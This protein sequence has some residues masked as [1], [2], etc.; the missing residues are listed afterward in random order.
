[1]SRIVETIRADRGGAYTNVVQLTDALVEAGHEAFVVGPFEQ[2]PEIRGTV[3]PLDVNR[4]VS[5]G[6]D[7]R[8]VTRFAGIVRELEPDLVHGHGSKGGLLARLGRLGS[9]RTPVVFTPHLYSFDNYFARPAQRHL[10]RGVERVL[11]PLASRVTA[12][13][14]AERLSAAK[15]G[16]ASR[17]RLVYNGVDPIRLDSVHP[18]I[19]ELRARGPVVCTVAELRDSKGVPRLVDA[20]AIVRERHPDAQLA[21]AGDGA[22]RSLVE[23]R[24]AAHGL[25][26]AAHL[27]GATPGADQVLAGAS[28]F[29]NA[30]YAEGFPYTVIEAMSAGLPVV[31]TDVGGTSEAI[32]TDGEAGILVPPG[33]TATLAEA[34]TALLDDPDRARRLGAAAHRR[35][36]EHFTAERMVAAAFAVYGELGIPF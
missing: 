29:V 28:L 23:Q 19:A 24:I 27:L 18:V 10:Y 8:A 31:A 1:M 9:P 25:A 33:D 35:Y 21:I 36:E 7:L 32:G 14:E 20:F 2:R 6:G 4:E 34:I 16:P 15:I 26:D 17:T 11:A 13:C 3:V 22:E 5:L 12:C 30:A